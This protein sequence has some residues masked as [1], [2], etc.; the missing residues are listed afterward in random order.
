MLLDIR[1]KNIKYIAICSTNTNW[2]TNI[3]NCFRVLNVGDLLDWEFEHPYLTD[4]K[5]INKLLAIFLGSKDDLK[6]I[7]NSKIVDIT[8]INTVTFSENCWIPRNKLQNTH[9]KRVNLKSKADAIVIPNIPYEVSACSYRMNTTLKDSLILYSKLEDTF[10]FLPYYPEQWANDNFKTTFNKYVFNSIGHYLNS[11]YDF[12]DLLIKEHI[13]PSDC[14][15]YYYGKIILPYSVKELD[16]IHTILNNKNIIIED[17]LNYYNISQQQPITEEALNSINGMLSSNES[18][19]QKLGL[20]LL[21]N[22][23]IFP[24]LSKAILLVYNNLSKLTNN[25]VHRSPEFTYFI[26]TFYLEHLVYYR[27]YSDLLAHIFNITKN[28]NDKNNT[29]RLILEFITKQSENFV[30]DI[31][32]IFPFIS[33]NFNINKNEEYN[34]NSGV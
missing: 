33:L 32:R 14:V 25:R 16:N 26:N 2:F 3:Q 27:N 10:Y 18:H 30:I 17:T 12:K 22:H 15:D 23:N 29:L 31:N 6:N 4:Y 5:Y 7:I 20:R 1:E 8:S 9:L 21:M 19:I 11:L 24:M 34:S 13:L 28:V